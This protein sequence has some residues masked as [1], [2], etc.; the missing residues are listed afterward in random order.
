MLYKALVSFSGLISMS[1]GEVK[2]ITNSTI[3]DDL[4]KAGYIIPFEPK[5]EKAKTENAEKPKPKTKRK[6]N[7]DGN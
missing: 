1:G 4:L 5:E 6:E 2:E 7:K 3:S